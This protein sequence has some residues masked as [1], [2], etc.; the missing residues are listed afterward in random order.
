MHT[1]M[2]IQQM[3]DVVLQTTYD[4]VAGNL[5]REWSRG[6]PGTITDAFTLGLVLTESG[7]RQLRLAPL[8]P[9]SQLRL[10]KP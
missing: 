8:E 6:N 7:L 1:R 5:R 9:F 3:S 2:E 10:F 4:R